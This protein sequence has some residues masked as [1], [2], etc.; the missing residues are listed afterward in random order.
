ME[1]G[2]IS[3]LV[4]TISR[5][6]SLPSV[7]SIWREGGRVRVRVRVRVRRKEHSIYIYSIGDRD[8]VRKRIEGTW[9]PENTRVK[10]GAAGTGLCHISHGSDP[11]L[12][13]FS[14]LSSR[15]TL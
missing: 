14:L 7:L 1:A 10:V 4:V 15:S 2:V 6:D 8:V 5:L 12:S 9:A 3:Y 11:P 13:F